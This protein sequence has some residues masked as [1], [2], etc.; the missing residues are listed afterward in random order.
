MSC[1]LLCGRGLV[2]FVSCSCICVQVQHQ[3]P[4]RFG[5]IF[6]S[7]V[8]HTLTAAS[9]EAAPAAREDTGTSTTEQ[10]TEL[11]NRHPKSNINLPHT[12]C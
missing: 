8:A 4:V 12:Y 1:E 6:K 5:F 3:L 2:L 7:S 11:P 9:T 10:P